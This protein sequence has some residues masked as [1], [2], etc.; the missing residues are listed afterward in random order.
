M[1]TL[2]PIPQSTSADLPIVTPARGG[3]NQGK[4]CLTRIT[5][6]GVRLPFR[7]NPLHSY[8]VKLEDNHS[9]LAK[10]KAILKQG[11]LSTSSR[12]EAYLLLD[13]VLADICKKKNGGSI[14]GETVRLGIDA[15]MSLGNLLLKPFRDT[16]GSEFF[17]NAAERTNKMLE[18]YMLAV[19]LGDNKDGNAN[20]HLGRYW[21][22]AAIEA[23]NGRRK[24]LAEKA[25]EHFTKAQHIA[26]KTPRRG[27]DVR[28]AFY[29]KTLQVSNGLMDDPNS[30][31][32]SL[33]DF[34]KDNAERESYLF[35]LRESMPTAA[36]ISNEVA[37]LE[38]IV[39]CYQKL[40]AKNPR[41]QPRLN[42]FKVILAEH[43]KQ[44]APERARTLLL[45]GENRQSLRFWKGVHGLMEISR[46]PQLPFV[47]TEVENAKALLK[48]EK[49]ADMF[50]QDLIPLKIS[51]EKEQIS[52]N[53][54][55]WKATRK[56]VY[57]D[58]AKFRKSR[59]LIFKSRSSKSKGKGFSDGKKQKP[60]YKT[61]VETGLDTDMIENALGKVP[62]RTIDALHH[63]F[64]PLGELDIGKI[65]AIDAR[66][67]L[68][69]VAFVLVENCANITKVVMESKQLPHELG[70][71]LRIA[72]EL[73]SCV[74]YCVQ[75]ATVLDEIAANIVCEAMYARLYS[76]SLEEKRS[77]TEDLSVITRRYSTLRDCWE[78]LKTCNKD[79]ASP[80]VKKLTVLLEKFKNA[81]GSVDFAANFDFAANYANLLEILNEHNASASWDTNLDATLEA[82]DENAR[83]LIKSQYRINEFQRQYAKQC[84]KLKEGINTFHDV[85]KQYDLDSQ[86][87]NKKG[88]D[89]QFRRMQLAA[90][91]RMSLIGITIINDVCNIMKTVPAA[92]HYLGPATV[93]GTAL[94]GSVNI[95]AAGFNVITQ[96]LDV[97]VSIHDLV[98]AN[99]TN[100]KMMSGLK[101]AVTIADRELVSFATTLRRTT[102][103]SKAWA[104]L[105]AVS[106]V[107]SLGNY[108][109]LLL[110]G[111]LS[112]AGTLAASIIGVA[113]LVI[114]S[115]GGVLGAVGASLAIGYMTYRFITWFRRTKRIKML[116]AAAEGDHTAQKKVRQ[117]YMEKYPQLANKSSD[118]IANFSAEKLV[119]MSGKCAIYVL[120]RRLKCESYR[121]PPESENMQA[122]TTYK[123]LRHFLEHEQILLLTQVDIGDAVNTMAKRIKIK[124]HA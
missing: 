78:I 96:F 50:L 54:K 14:D 104:S 51:V 21:F 60:N 113:G 83:L 74:A 76:M 7:S 36:E 80:S 82:F 101:D 32:P 103:F 117:N 87:V 112:L 16:Q 9:C 64:S 45:E 119:E 52:T 102:G 22:S 68:I 121:I 62:D 72:S 106:S 98:S 34:C 71:P 97:C 116:K 24:E 48:G 18:S 11:G 118:D 17:S 61:L 38:N 75:H 55:A 6:T 120:L 94:F 29:L 3:G 33:V 2:H 93:G 81:H 108:G 43:I 26:E 85:V 46:A 41:Y 57:L 37:T 25:T 44:T 35:E 20:Y 100:K 15:A 114:L 105:K 31:W 49:V 65:T 10:A 30:Y 107:L 92:I 63:A 39:S 27:K 110:G 73:E 90:V 124:P 4:D 12:V 1:V 77:D 58:A 40:A 95:I 42:K 79:S 84:V 67:S 123:Y 19:E 47:R 88:L 91:A 69:N 28:T 89:T 109:L 53:K 115:A 59:N 66:L 70:L 8:N 56:E 99:K 5:K 13:R 122:L 86:L 111:C 23:K